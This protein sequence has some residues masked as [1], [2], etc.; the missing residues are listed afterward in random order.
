MHTLF[1]I[2]FKELKN[3]YITN[4]Y[5]NII[6]FIIYK[7]VMKIKEKVQVKVNHVFIMLAIQK[8]LIN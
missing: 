7:K 8:L 5:K 4:Y 6:I 1:N 3:K 2:I